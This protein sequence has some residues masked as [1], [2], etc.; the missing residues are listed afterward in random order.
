MLSDFERKL[1]R[2][3]YNFGLK[4]KR[5]PTK[6]ELERLTNHEYADIEK[7]LDSLVQKEYIFWPDRPALDTITILEAWEREQQTSRAK[8]SPSTTNSNI[9]YWTKY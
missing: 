1:L 8:F 2:I 5:N 4:Y 3:L 6:P 7:T 9:D